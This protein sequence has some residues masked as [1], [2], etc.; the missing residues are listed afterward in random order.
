MR[1]VEKK[2]S[3]QEKNETPGGG[4]VSHKICYAEVTVNT[5]K[6]ISTTMRTTWKISFCHDPCVWVCARH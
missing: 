6:K 1:C 5:K 3:V 4:G 2:K